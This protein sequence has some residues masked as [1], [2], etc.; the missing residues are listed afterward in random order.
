MI[1]ISNI[2]HRAKRVWRRGRALLPGLALSLA[3]LLANPVSA[4][5]AID[6]NK[7]ATLAAIF[8]GATANTACNAATDRIA[9]DAGGAILVCNAGT[10]TAAVGGGGGGA[11]GGGGVSNS[12]GGLAIAPNSG[13]LNID[14]SNIGAWVSYT[15]TNSAPTTTTALTTILTNTANFELQNNTCQ[16]AALAQNASC[17]FQI[18]AKSQS[19][20]TYSGRLSF[21]ASHHQVDLGLLG[22]ASNVPFNCGSATVLYDGFTYNTV[23][24]AGQCWLKQNLR[25]TVR[26]DGTFIPNSSTGR[27]CYNHD[28]ANCTARGALYNYWTAINYA[29][30][31]AW[32]RGICPPGFHIPTKAEVHHLSDSLKTPTMTCNPDRLNTLDC[33]SAG[34]AMKVGGS[35]G[36]EFQ[37]AGYF[38]PNSGSFAGWDSD[39]DYWVVDGTSNLA[40]YMNVY[41]S[42]PG[43]GRWRADQDYS[44]PVRCLK[45]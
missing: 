23:S 34:N 36:L 32:T 21:V 17:T 29:V 41:V 10:W 7:A 35:S 8:N 44:F 11:G 4:Q 33:A 13:A 43:V 22:T 28:V 31:G 1:V 18:R 2:Q 30:N 15:L 42:Q 19:N 6:A 25:T 45:D 37:Y 27:L 16:G 3:G 40:W 38:T 9:K 24:V 39:V 20:G 14:G 12:I 5:I 26:P